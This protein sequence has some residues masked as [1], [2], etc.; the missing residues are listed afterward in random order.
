MDSNIL[1]VLSFA[2]LVLWVERQNRI[3]LLLA[4]AGA[5]LTTCFLQPKG[6]CLFLSFLAVAWLFGRGWYPLA[7]LS[8]AY[9]AVGAACFAWFGAQ[10]ALKDLIYATAIWPLTTYSATNAVPY[11]FEFRELYWK[12]WTESLVPAFSPIVGIPASVALMLPF[13]VVLALPLL[14]ACLALS[15]RKTAFNRLTWPYWICGSAL[16]VSE[17]QRRDMIH[18]VYGSPVLLV[19]AFHLWRQVKSRFA[20]LALQTVM[21]C[22]VMLALVNPMVALLAG[23]R[24]VTRRGVV[25]SSVAR[26][27]VLDFLMA[28]TR[29]GDPIF[30]YPYAPLYYFLTATENPT[31]FNFMMYNFH[32]ESQF[33]EAVQALERSQVRYVVW[34]RAFLEWAAVWFPAYRQP[35]AN[36]LIMEPYLTEHYTVVGNAGGGYQL[37]ERKNSAKAPKIAIN[38][39]TWR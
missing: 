9:A 15:L 25:Y 2:A 35:P 4:G 31:R 13:A 28:H 39:R 19:L 26:D 11:G 38:A 36:K 10:G 34:D 23:N 17:M 27:A 6:M 14:L 3:A 18:L 29:A 30:V 32:T 37:L 16:F 5:G 8:G 1:A 7:E 22:A 12:G 24:T 20:A 33:R 21:A